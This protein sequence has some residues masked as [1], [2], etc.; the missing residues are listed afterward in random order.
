MGSGKMRV[1]IYRPSIQEA[2]LIDRFMRV[3]REVIREENVDLEQ[4]LREFV[5][6]ID[7][8]LDKEQFYG[9]LDLIKHEITGFSVLDP[10]LERDDIE[11]ISVIEGNPIRAYVRDR[12]W[13]DTD[14]SITSRE[15]IVEIAN[16]M[17]YS[18]DRRLTIQEPRMNANLP[19]GSRLHAVIPPISDKA[20]LTIRKFRKK[21]F[22]PRELVD[23]GTISSEAMAFLWIATQLDTNILV[24]GST[25]SG[26]TTTLNTMLAFVPMDQ[27]I[28]SIEETPELV[29]FH[30]HR[31]R[32][33]VNKERGIGMSDLVRDTLRMRPDKVIVGEVRS[34][35]E[36][37][38]WIDTTLA[39]QGKGSFATF[40]G[41]SVRE[42]INRLKSSGVS[43]TDLS[44]LDL[45]VVQRRWSIPGEP[46][47]R[48]IFEIAEINW[49]SGVRVNPIFT[50]DPEKDRLVRTRNR[51]R[52][53]NNARVFLG[54]SKQRMNRM[55]KFIERSPK[56]LESAFKE[57]SKFRW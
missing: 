40:H 42:T 1:D 51:S 57:I 34:P 20:S 48:R 53:L 25:G 9:I 29:I 11:E 10:L 16:K 33:V 31:I 26:K 6:A 52:L 43:E 18:L 23:N 13:I 35:D 38:A 22:S 37:R 24:S 28:I 41:L 5:N 8:E 47:R 14:I 32:L 54:I 19:D 17:A 15:K 46:D 3:H 27:R 7:I 49:E 55:K 56:S 44:G 36:I 50:Y 39:G 30:P 12:G 2:R 45:V 4:L 21:P